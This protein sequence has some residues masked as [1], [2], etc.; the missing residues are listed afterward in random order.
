MARKE[1]AHR[2]EARGTGSQERGER[3][4]LAPR[5]SSLL[6]PVGMDEVLEDGQGGF[7]SLRRGDHDL[8]I[9]ALP[10]RAQYAFS[11]INPPESIPGAAE[12]PPA[13]D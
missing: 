9:A 1:A 7:R 12:G 10:I 2:I 8:L 4:P 6:F 3:K 13:A 5:T 11:R